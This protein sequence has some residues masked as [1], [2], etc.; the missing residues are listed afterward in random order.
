MSTFNTDADHLIRS[1]VRRCVEAR[2]VWLVSGTEGYARV[3]SQRHHGKQVALAW[4]ERS[5]AARWADVLAA[6]PRIESVRLTDF[7][8]ETLT[9]IGRLDLLLGPN[10]T[11]EPIEPELKAIELSQAVRQGMVDGF[12]TEALQ[13]HAVWLLATAAGHVT[14]QRPTGVTVLP[15]W[16]SRGDTMHVASSLS[17]ESR[18][19]RVPL[20]EFIG[21]TVMQCVEQRWRI[22]PGYIAGGG[23][24]DL[25]AWDVKAMLNGGGTATLRV[26]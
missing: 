23:A 13:H 1:F 6:K 24:I 15:V 10:W 4:S 21:R 11:D 17:E 20:S 2:H 7:L 8:A 16:S 19:V 5:E 25:A 14:L 3:D 18:A 22:A 9:A 26:A 12:A